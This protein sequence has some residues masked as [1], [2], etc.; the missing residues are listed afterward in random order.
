MKKENEGARKSK[1]MANIAKKNETAKASAK[2]S[3]KSQEMQLRELHVNLTRKRDEIVSAWNLVCECL[4][5]ND[6]A[7][8]ARKGARAL[9]RQ[10]YGIARASQLLYY[11]DFAALEEWHKAN[12]ST[13]SEVVSSLLKS[14]DRVEVS[15]YVEL[16]IIAGLTPSVD[17]FCSRYLCTETP[18]NRGG[19][20][21]KAVQSKIEP[22]ILSEALKD[23][24][25]TRPATRNDWYD[26]LETHPSETLEAAKKAV[27]EVVK[28]HTDRLIPALCAHGV[29]VADMYYT[30]QSAVREWVYF[31][32]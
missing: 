25:E 11:V 17:D 10:Y 16:C 18:A 26:W 29:E 2:A 24:S 4:A 1:D 6:E 22:S 30:S 5:I 19:L 21:L 9:D 3:E 32:I 23:V 27:T 28:I 12:S 8:R 7:P 15:V 20:I 14:F 31:I 13:S